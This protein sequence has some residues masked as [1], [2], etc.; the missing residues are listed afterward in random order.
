[1]ARE[2]LSP[3]EVA[4]IL[5][6]SRQHVVRMVNRHDLPAIWVGRVIRISREELDKFIAAGG[7]RPERERVSLPAYRRRRRRAV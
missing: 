7:C 6:V 3:T 2:F 1:M 4:E 5:G